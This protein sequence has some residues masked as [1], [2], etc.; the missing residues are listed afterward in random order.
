M[1]KWN[2]S[3]PSD[4]PV[5]SNLPRAQPTNDM[6]KLTADVQKLVDTLTALEYWFDADDEILA[7]MSNDMLADHNRQ[8]AKIKSALTPFRK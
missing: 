6:P 2:L 7:D 8:V 1:A 4:A 3:N 5:P